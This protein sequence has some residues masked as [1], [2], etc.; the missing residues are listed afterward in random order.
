[1][2]CGNLQRSI[3]WRVS[4]LMIK[5]PVSPSRY[6]LYFCFSSF[7]MVFVFLPQ[8]FLILFKATSEIF[9]CFILCFEAIHC[10][11]Q[12]NY[13]L[14]FM[15]MLHCFN[16]TFFPCFFCNFYN[17][18]IHTQEKYMFFFWWLKYSIFFH[19]SLWFHTTQAH[20]SIFFI[21]TS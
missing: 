7:M 3:I 18:F 6:A 11:P 13:I 5:I 16:T 4:F 15:V 21:F 10:L 2:A 12:F 19:L 1:M 14:F 20:D 8:C 17:H 9:E